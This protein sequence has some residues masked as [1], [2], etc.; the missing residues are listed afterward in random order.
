M[1]GKGSFVNEKESRSF[2]TFFKNKSHF[3][4]FFQILSHKIKLKNSYSKLE[5]NSDFKKF[6]TQTDN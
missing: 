6:N 2:Y 5:L 4:Q 3:I 1:S